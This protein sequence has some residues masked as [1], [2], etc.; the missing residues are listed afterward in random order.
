MKYRF[1]H[2]QEF[3]RNHNHINGIE[4]F[5]S[6]IKRKMRKQNGI[7]R[8]KFYFYLK[9]SEFRF[10]NRNGNIY[11]AGFNEEVQ[12]FYQRLPSVFGNVIFFLVYC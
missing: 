12:R 6:Y 7:A 5:C 10:N 9:E 2:S 8:Y 3:V 1:N 4:S 11:S